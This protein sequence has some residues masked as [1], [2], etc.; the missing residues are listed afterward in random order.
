MAKNAYYVDIKSDWHNKWANI[1]GF[2][3]IY[4]AIDYAVNES[5]T[6]KEISKVRV[7]DRDYDKAILT[8]DLKTL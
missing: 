3:D 5:K 1:N 7:W 6:N 8:I 4:E 2:T